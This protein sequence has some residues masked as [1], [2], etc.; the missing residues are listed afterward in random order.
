MKG[1]FTIFKSRCTRR[2][3]GLTKPSN[4]EKMNKRANE[5]Y[6]KEKVANIDEGHVEILLDNEETISKKLSNASPMRKFAEIGKI[7]LAMIKDIKNG[8]YP[9]VPW[10]TIASATLALLYFLNPLDI[11]PDFIPGIGYID[12][13]AIMSI[14][15]GWIETDLHEYLDWKLEQGETKTS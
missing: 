1:V 4:F 3:N 11:I 8:H 7:M 12:D 14:A 13:I 15:L 10:F 6:A 5:S 2:L 9:E